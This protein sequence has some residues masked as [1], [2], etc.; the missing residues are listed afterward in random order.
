MT[1]QNKVAHLSRGQMPVMLLVPGLLKQ[2]PLHRQKP[3]VDVLTPQQAPRG[4]R[5]AQQSEEQKG[6]D[7][8]KEDRHHPHLATKPHQPGDPLTDRGEVVAHRQ[9]QAADGVVEEVS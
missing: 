9:R 1:Q 4:H 7:D 5:I 3:G 2:Q 6:P 8:D